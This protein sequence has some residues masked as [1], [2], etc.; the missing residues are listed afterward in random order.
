MRVSFTMTKSKNVP[1]SLSGPHIIPIHISLRMS[2]RE[3]VPTIH[4]SFLSLVKSVK[5][6][7]V[8]NEAHDFTGFGCR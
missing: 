5:T 7:R 2:L 3:I 6:S 1:I 8:Y 4:T